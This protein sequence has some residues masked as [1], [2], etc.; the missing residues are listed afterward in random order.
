MLAAA[1]ILSTGASAQNL[2]VW[3]SEAI[4]PDCVFHY[5]ESNNTDAHEGQWCFQGSPDPWH[6][7]GI[8]LQCQ[9]TWRADISGL[10]E[11][12][13]AAKSD[14][15]GR[16]F[17]FRIYG[18]PH[19]SNPIYIDDYIEGG[20]LDTTYRMVSIPI[21]ALKTPEWEVDRIEILYF[22][23]AEPS[24]GHQIFIDDVWAMDLSPT[25]IEGVE[26][27]AGHVL[28]LEMQDRFD[29]DDAR[30]ASHYSLTSSTDP[31]F[32]SAVMPTQVGIRHY[33]EG[34]SDSGP[35]PQISYEIFLIFSQ[36]MSTGSDY[37]LTVDSIDD[38]AGNGFEEP[39]SHS[40]IYSEI[41]QVNGTVKANQ[42]GYLPDG[43]KFGYAG[44]YLGDAGAMDIAPTT[45]VVRN[46]LDDE[47][48]FV[49]TPLLRGDDQVLSGEEVYSCDF[50]GLTEPGSYYL[51]VP[52]LGRSH[53]FTIGEGAYTDALRT[54]ARG[55]YYQRCGIELVP[56]AADPR[57]AHGECHTADALIHSSHVDS[58]LHG[59][60]V[61]G[62]A[63][64]MPGGWHDAG[65]YGRYVPTAAVALHALLTAYELYPQNYPDDAWG[66]PESGN[67]IP[68]LLD[69]IK[70]ELD[71][72]SA[73]QS[74]D[75]GV[76][77]KVTTTDWAD[78]MPEDDLDTLW[79]SPK[80]THTTAQFAAVMAAASRSFTPFLPDLASS[81]LE[82]AEAAW[83][84]LG[85]HPDAYP[86]A[87]FV[88][89]AGIGGG[90]YGDP[91]GDVDER[92]WAAAEL[93]KTTGD[94]AYHDAF[95]LYWPQNPPGWGWN[96]FQHSQLKASWA[97]VTTTFPVDQDW[98]AAIKD[99]RRIGL[100]N[101]LIVRTEDNLYRNGYRSD[102]LEWIGWGS[103]AQSTRYSLDSIKGSYLL[104]DV[105]YLDYA[106]INLGP[107]LGNN[108]Q[109][110]SYI[111]GVGSRYPLDPLQHPSMADG[112]VEPVPGLPVFGPMSH[113]P[114]S[115]E[116]YYQAQATENL[117]P[118][119]EQV[120]DPYPILRRYYDI[121]ELVH[122]SEFTI[123]E[124][125]MATAALGFFGEGELQP[126]SG[127]CFGDAG[128]GT[129]CPCSNDNDGSV[130]GSGCDNGVF[131]SGARLSGA[132][133]AS[134]S[135]DTLILSASNLE[136]N[137]SGLYFQADNDLSPGLV[138]G[139]GLRCTG[140][141]LK[142]LQVR[143]SD[144]AGGSATT[145]SISVKAGN[146][147]A[148][149]IK[150]YQCWYRSTTSPPCGSGSNEFNTTNG[151][152][153]VW[154]P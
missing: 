119:G 95:A 109:G 39:F 70:W 69:E 73:M 132:G 99:E 76:F 71:W 123:S 140:G 35:V 126:G 96:D 53:E 101:Y 151:Y 50:A 63:V 137:T 48:A 100:D 147:V 92:A 128:A 102:V 12:R 139:N 138:F 89:P 33:V 122:M 22:G 27:L 79:I 1:A 64:A 46:V 9:D 144:G 152:E 30:I 143:I 26:A 59:G 133:G 66:I 10:D 141:S 4:T 87:G 136:P 94:T 149:D 31:A 65:D 18:W 154:L 52:G 5:G 121:S 68:D 72:L 60:E 45:F 108:P 84:F 103:Y 41:N 21:D 97:Y 125:A 37:L 23:H 114:M 131:A 6:S 86:P 3:D 2:K 67:G 49:G 90:E 54:T 56:P 55:F 118:A 75:G 81:C 88:N 42:V 14:M 134:I 7:P 112:V 105:S 15:P 135:E 93:Y 111:T 115:N 34:F 146:I 110:L 24:D 20:A 142:R 98:V 16:T 36:A 62:S 13:F 145:I 80:T 120:G 117:Y 17:Q 74:A 47:S 104:D 107:Q 116:Y 51:H 127:Y 8:V 106:K 82:Q 19:E 25:A 40:F 148:G 113:I 32:A 57:W 78:S 11:I 124:M 150:R 91:L 44:N 85:N 129:P 130:P 28:K 58:A 153:I 61:I 77:F 38:P 29:L 43:P 83:A